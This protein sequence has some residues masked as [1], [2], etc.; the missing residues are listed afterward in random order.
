[1][2]PETAIKIVAANI[3]ANAAADVEWENTP[4]V[5]EYDWERIVLRLS[6]MA[7]HPFGFNEAITL[8]EA[9]AERTDD[10]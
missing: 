7:P 10:G 2:T 3:L 1:M 5:G 4:D 9:R 6:A 8:L